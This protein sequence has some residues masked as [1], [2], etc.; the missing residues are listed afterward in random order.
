MFISSTFASG[1]RQQHTLL[2]KECMQFSSQEKSDRD[3]EIF[4]ERGMLKSER[5]Q[6]TRRRESFTYV[7]N[8]SF[9]LEASKANQLT[10][11]SSSSNMYKRQKRVDKYLRIFY[12]AF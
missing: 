4:E 2:W 11:L 5:Y 1:K 3:E 9:F 6:Q 10:F 12:A 8:L 7:V